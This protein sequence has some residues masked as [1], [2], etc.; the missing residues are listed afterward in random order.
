MLFSLSLTLAYQKKK[1]HA[2][3]S[4]GNAIL[5]YRSISVFVKA[6]T[7]VG[8]QSLNSCTRQWPMVEYVRCGDL[9]YSC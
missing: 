1:I 5:P 3:Y 2:G 7:R 8:K 6:L 9:F 4:R